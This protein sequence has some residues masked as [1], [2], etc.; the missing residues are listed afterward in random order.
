MK[1]LKSEEIT[2][3]YKQPWRGRF[4]IATGSATSVT[5][6]THLQSIIENLGKHVGNDLDSKKKVIFVEG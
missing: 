1:W 4:S 3:E 6:D 5:V 2:N